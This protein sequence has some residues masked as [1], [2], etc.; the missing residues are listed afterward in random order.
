M[1]KKKKASGPGVRKEEEARRSNVYKK[2]VF[3]LLRELGFA[4]AI[5]YIDKSMLRVLYSAR[6]T[7]IRID[8]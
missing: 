2:R 1:P 6:P 4:D 3:T 8:A 5:P 7:L